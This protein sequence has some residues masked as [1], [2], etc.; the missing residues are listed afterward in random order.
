MF[1]NLLIFTVDLLLAENN[2]SELIG[3]LT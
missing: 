3:I 1:F 2:H